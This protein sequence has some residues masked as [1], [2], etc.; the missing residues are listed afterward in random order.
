[1]LGLMLAVGGSLR[2]ETFTLSQTSFTATGD[3]DLFVVENF[4]PSLNGVGY[5]G[6]MG[7][8]TWSL[9]NIATI[10][11]F[12]VT[13]DKIDLRSTTVN[14]EVQFGYGYAYLFAF[15]YDYIGLEDCSS[16]GSGSATNG[17]G[18]TIITITDSYAGDSA[19]IVLHGVTKNTL[20]LSNFLLPGQSLGVPPTFVGST[21][22]LSVAQNSSATNIKS[23]LHVSDADSGQTLT[24]SVSAAASHGTVTVSG[25]TATTGS[26]DITPGG[27]L[28]YTPAPGYTGS[29]SFT[30]QVSDG[31]ATATRTITVTVTDATPPTIVSVNRHAPSGQATNASSVTFRVTYSEAVTNISTANFALEPV[32]GSTVAGTIASVSGTGSTRDVT[33]TIT[34]GTGE[35]TLRAIN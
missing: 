2:A 16:N 18:S 23:L 19:L 3:A 8:S 29:D 34:G 6:F 24:W 33:V 27:T 28:T 10:H 7:E 22:T 14:P 9:M 30:V 17:S 21:T 31:S 35:F 25:A 5:G 4:H 32:G 20:T 13:K 11:G 1:M 12:D 26:T 15:E